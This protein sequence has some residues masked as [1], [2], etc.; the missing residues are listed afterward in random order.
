[1]SKPQFKIIK[2]E[3]TLQKKVGYGEI[4]EATISRS[5]QILVNNNIDFKE[6][7]DP[8]LDNLRNT[9]SYA[10]E[11]PE[12]IESIL[13]DLIRPVM[14]L[15]ANGAM[16]KY[17]LV[18]H[19]AGIMLSFLEHITQLTRDS[20]EIIQAHERTLTLIVTKGIQGDGGSLGAQLTQELEG[21]CNRYY[22]KNPDKFK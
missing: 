3:N 11:N 12:K 6:V 5:E 1:M 16:F 14:D 9:I 13:P 15:K 4:G 10:R 8:V 21:V 22:R 17:N 20:L 18:G 7:A 2:V 19:L